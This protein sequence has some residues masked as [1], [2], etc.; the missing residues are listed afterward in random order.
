[1]SPVHS[2][3]AFRRQHTAAKNLSTPQMRALRKELL[4]VRA[5]VERMELAQSTIELRQAVIRFSW[6]KFVLPGFA[7]MRWGVRSATSK[8]IGGLLKQYPLLSSI[9]SL[10]LAKPLRTSVTATA[11]PVLKWGSVVLAGWEAYRIWQQIR[12]ETGGRAGKGAGKD[13]RNGAGADSSEQAADAG[14]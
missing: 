2:D 13:I 7:S 10:L 6:L 11:K 4:I 12:R 8:G 9:V 1:M 14:G 3:A 5:D